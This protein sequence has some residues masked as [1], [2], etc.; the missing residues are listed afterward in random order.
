[1]N[2]LLPLF[3]LLLLTP[4]LSAEQAA[5]TPDWPTWRHDVLRSGATTHA[6]AGNLTLA[7]SR[8]LGR[9]EA[10]FD[11]HFRLCADEANEPV[12]VGGVLF[13]PSNSSDGVTAYDLSSGVEKWRF[14][15]EGPV[16]FAPVVEGGLVFFGSDDGCVYAVDAASGAL[17]WKTRAA[18][19]DR[20]DYRM[21]VNDRLCSRWPVRGGLV[22]QNGVVYAGCGLWPSEGVFALALDA[23]T[24][25]VKWRNGEIAQIDN[26]L[27][28]HGKMADIGLPP[29]GYLAIIGGK[30]AMPSGRALAAFL[31]PASGKLDP[32]AGYWTKYYP[33]PR[34]SWALAGHERFWFQ[35]GALMGTNADEIEKLPHGPVPWDD[36]LALLQK[37]AAVAE[38]LAATGVIQ[39]SEVNGVRSVVFDPRH[40]GLGV[41]ITPE[42]ATA[43]QLFQ[44]AE[45][46]VLHLAPTGTRHEIGETALPVFTA[47]TM[48]R[49]EYR[50]IKALAVERGATHVKPP[51]YDVL[52]AYDLDSG[53]WRIDAMVLIGKMQIK[54]RLEFKMLWELDTPGM[55]VKLLAGDTLY[56]AGNGEIAAVPLPKAGEKPRITWRVKVP[57][58]PVGMIAA[59]G[60]LI[61]T[62]NSGKLLVFGE[63]AAAELPKPEIAKWERTSPFRPQIKNLRASLP[64]AGNAL[65]LGWGM[66]ELAKELALQS[67]LRVIVVENDAAKAAAAR[68][69]VQNLGAWA[70]RLHIISGTSDTLKLPPYFAELVMCEH[71]Q[72]LD[73]GAR[74]WTRIALDCLRPHSGVAILPLREQLIDQARKH[75]EKI[76]GYAFSTEGRLTTIRRNAAPNGADDWTHETAGAGNTFASTDTL[77]VPPFA[78]LWYSGGIDH[79]FTPAFEYHHDRNPYPLIAS[80]RLFMLAGRDLHAADAY[81]G[82]HLWHAVI[83]ESEK[84]ELRHGDHRT[85]SR[86]TDSNYLATP[87][88]VYVPHESEARVFDAATGKELATLKVPDD[89]TPWDE[90]R[91]S[92]DTFFISLGGKLVALDR[93]SGAVKW[94]HR[95]AQGRAAFALGSE[96]VFVAGYAV[97]RGQKAEK[98]PAME[99]TLSVLDETNGETLW[100]A[101][102][103]APARPEQGTRVATWERIF[104]DNALKPTLHYQAARNLVLAIVDRHRFHAFDATSG[105]PLWNRSTQARLADLVG[106]EPPTL[107]RDLIVCHDG[108]LLDPATGQPAAGT[109]KVGGRGVGCNRYVGSDALITFR[110]ASACFLDLETKERTHLSSTR[111]GC[112]NNMIPAAGLLNA[113]N[114]AHGCVCNYPFLTSFAMMHLPEAAKWGPTVKPDAQMNGRPNQN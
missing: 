7:W 77:A 89:A 9:P 66:G 74:P 22:L 16:R 3:L 78:L 93:Q 57:G 46:P 76:G 64:S 52:R 15:T 111:P 82:R 34:G 102:L 67:T 113:P 36:F 56:L 33:V 61:V 75:G 112:T 97:E 50:D 65:V 59:N 91:I 13:V 43:G 69:A 39:V 99:T 18:P 23:A 17:K 109:N 10:A 53:A 62:T 105:S 73:N 63:K 106:F 110:S 96:K 60:K 41:N 68:S 24:G 37:P 79:S 44:M 58:V 54:R 107:T 32:Y 38:K 12:A 42:T 29:H 4:G 20:L 86:P 92:G 94:Q 71:T 70:R 87:D 83:P 40:P 28:Q 2:R 47:K 45:R 88:R 108:A 11:Y 5:S 81:T 48:F 26:G 85:T 35:G 51:A 90:C 72:H 25:A 100:T 101:P 95:S 55:A 49:S 6:L 27:Q 80:G 31:D 21:L 104:Q 114:F 103:T 14:I 1:M 84:T 19:E 98:M 30:V 8:D